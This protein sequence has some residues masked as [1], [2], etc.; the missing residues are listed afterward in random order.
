LQSDGGIAGGKDYSDETAALIDQETKQ[1]LEQRNLHVHRMLEEKKN[2]L[3]AIAEKLL[4]KEVLFGTEFM[5][6]V[7]A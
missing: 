5:D 3:V 2:T 7:K 1:I 6:M 4:E